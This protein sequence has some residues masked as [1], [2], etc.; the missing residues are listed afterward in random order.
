MYDE[1]DVFEF[2]SVDWGIESFEDKLNFVNS[3]LHDYI[4]G[5]SNSLVFNVMKYG[6]E[7]VVR[8]LTGIYC[9]HSGGKRV[10]LETTD[11]SGKR[12]IYWA[13]RHTFRNGKKKTNKDFFVTEEYVVKTNEW[14]EEITTLDRAYILLE[15]PSA[16]RIT[17]SIEDSEETPVNK[18]KFRQIAEK[19]GNFIID[20]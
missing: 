18:S 17:P 14:Q 19:I 1:R 4:E 11:N 5:C 7:D 15:A 8:I 12:N 3:E 13:G 16:V 10:V 9:G 20:I 6:Q 2:S